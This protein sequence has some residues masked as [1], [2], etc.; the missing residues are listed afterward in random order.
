MTDKT[1]AGMARAF[2][3]PLIFLA[4]TATAQAADQNACLQL[5]RLKTTQVV[6]NKT[7]NAIDIQGK[8]YTVHMNG[9]CVGLSKFSELLTFRRAAGIGDELGC[10]QSG[11]RLGYSAPGGGARSDC[12]IDSVAAGTPPN[13]A[14]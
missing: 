7:L 10:L 4:L 3:A 13:P 5:N 6:D 8:T 9:A 1:I 2:T 12:T 11:D 14:Q